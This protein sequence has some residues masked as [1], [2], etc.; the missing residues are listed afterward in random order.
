MISLD[1]RDRAPAQSLVEFALVI[2]IFTML[3]LAVF[4]WSR[5]FATYISMANATREASRQA[6][7]IS[8]PTTHKVYADCTIPTIPAIAQ[9]CSDMQP[10]V[11]AALGAYTLPFGPGQFV[12]KNVC[13]FDAGITPT[14]S[15]IATCTAATNN[16][17]EPPSTGA[18]LVVRATYKVDF[19]P[20]MSVI[21]PG[22]LTFST[23]NIVYLE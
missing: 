7:V 21:V 8:N 5:T 13:L 2:G 10:V 17:P 20:F 3:M 15:D 11:N 18:V 19:M 14:P 22:G 1:Y 4:D 12:S 16:G 9:P 6:Q 23:S